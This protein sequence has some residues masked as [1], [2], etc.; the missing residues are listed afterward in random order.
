MYM[1]V[2]DIDIEHIQVK[3]PKK[4]DTMYLSKLGYDS[5]P[6]KIKLENVQIVKTKQFNEMDAIYF[7]V[8]NVTVKKLLK[9]EEKVVNVVYE[10]VEKW[11][12]NR[13]DPKVIEEFFDSCVCIDKKYGRVFKTRIEKNHDYDLK[14]GFVD[15]TMHAKHLKFNKQ[16]FNLQWGIEDLVQRESEMFFDDEALSRASD[17]TINSIDE[18][19]LGPDDDQ[20]LEIKST[21]E[22]R[23]HTMLTKTQ[24]EYNIVSDRLEKLKALTCQLSIG[25]NQVLALALLEDIENKMNEL[26]GEA[27]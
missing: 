19:L 23:L 22:S 7:K 8:N 10:N 16:S 15:I 24:H 9:I 18:L 1:S 5:Q 4:Y 21:M 26:D 2:H 25:N 14:L 13:L 17:D 20:L 11:F 3:A 27:K 12:R 6:L